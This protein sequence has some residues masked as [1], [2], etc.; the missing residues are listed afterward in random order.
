MT[1]PQEPHHM[2]VCNSFGMSSIAGKLLDSVCSQFHHIHRLRI[3]EHLIAY[4]MQENT[5]QLAGSHLG[6]HLQLKFCKG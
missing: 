6:P 4:G 1:M 2:E 3:S 5:P